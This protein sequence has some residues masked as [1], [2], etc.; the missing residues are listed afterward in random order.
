MERA[1]KPSGKRERQ[2][3]HSGKEDQQT[4][5]GDHST[6]KGAN[7]STARIINN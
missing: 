3:T 6:N 1:A 2:Q 5:L 4:I 7:I